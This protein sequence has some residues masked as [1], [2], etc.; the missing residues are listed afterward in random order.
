M[1]EHATIKSIH[2]TGVFGHQELRAD[3]KPR[4]NLL[5]GKNGSGKTTVLHILANLLQGD[6]IR[7]C[8]IR[9]ERLRFGL[10]TGQVLLLEQPADQPGVVG[11]SLDGTTLGQLSQAAPVG[12]EIALEFARLFPKRPVYLPAFRSILEAASD[13]EEYG[14][15]YRDSPDLRREIASIRAL[16]ERFLKDK[17]LPRS[18]SAHDTINSTA[19]KTLLSRRW[20]GKFVPVIR[21][22]SLADVSRRLDDEFET[23]YITVNI[24]N[25]D[26]FATVFSKVLQAVQHD[27]EPDSNEGVAVL[28]RRVQQQL[29]ALRPGQTQPA[30]VASQTWLGNEEKSVRRILAIY[31]KALTLRKTKEDEAYKGLRLFEA[32]FNKFVTPKTLRLIRGNLGPRG[33]RIQITESHSE[34]L[35]VLS[36]GERQVLTMLFCATHMSDDDGTMLIDEPEISLHIDWQRIIISEIMAQAG[37]R[38]VIVCTHAPEV[39]AEHRDSLVELRSQIWSGTTQEEVDT[40]GGGDLF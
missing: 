9:F 11:V 21:Y 30:D 10:S 25:Q 3:F 40:E 29:Q 37:D 32:S 26:T 23:A 1:S 7:F 12:P 2:F 13:R 16:E 22:P 5:H 31:D 38:Q 4:L 14:G 6:L 20:F 35:D 17:R 27:G 39:V 19:L 34:P 15:P 33:P 36:S 28:L 8:N 24:T 18:P